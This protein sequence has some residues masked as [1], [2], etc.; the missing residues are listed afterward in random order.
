MDEEPETSITRQFVPKPLTKNGPCYGLTPLMMV[1]FHDAYQLGLRVFGD[2]RD[3]AA[4][5]VMVQAKNGKPHRA[6]LVRIDG[7][8]RERENTESNE[9]LHGPRVDILFLETNRSVENLWPSTG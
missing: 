6:G 3:K 7:D 5:M 4:R 9:S 2:V 1:G 8:D